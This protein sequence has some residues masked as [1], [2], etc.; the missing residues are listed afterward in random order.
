MNTQS[1]LIRHSVK[2]LS[3]LVVASALNIL[4]NHTAAAATGAN[5]DNLTQCEK[6]SVCELLRESDT[7]TFNFVSLPINLP[8]P[9]PQICHDFPRCAKHT[10]GN[11]GE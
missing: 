2:S 10:D 8:F 6:N 7:Q 4:V 11:D 9:K 5:F 3:A 1:T